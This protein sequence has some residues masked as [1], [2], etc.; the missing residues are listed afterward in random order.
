MGLY[1]AS[2]TFGIPF[3]LMRNDHAV[4]ALRLAADRLEKRIAAV[5]SIGSMEN[6]WSAPIRWVKDG[7]VT[8]EPF[9]PTLGIPYL[10]I[11][12]IRL[13]FDERYTGPDPLDDPRM[14]TAFIKYCDVLR[15]KGA[16]LPV[17]TSR[18]QRFRFELRHLLTR[19]GV[20]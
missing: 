9:D 1:A 12:P 4:E 15:E 20:I 7:Q 8:T 18:W 14:H 3:D 13:T 11:S 2:G 5:R 6:F 16:G 10:S 19:M 17:F